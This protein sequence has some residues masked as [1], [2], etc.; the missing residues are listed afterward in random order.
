MRLGTILGDDGQRAC[1]IDGEEVVDL[2]PA[3][4]D[5]PGRVA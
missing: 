4:P 3:A 1:A 2:A 5:R